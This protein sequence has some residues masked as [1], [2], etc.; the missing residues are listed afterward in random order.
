GN[1][2]NSWIY[3]FTG[4][5]GDFVYL[6]AQNNNISGS[7]AVTIS[8]GNTTYKTSTSNGAYVIA[9]ASGSL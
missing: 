1:V 9:T 4:S 3:S 6:S 5:K 8:I 7:V 2:G